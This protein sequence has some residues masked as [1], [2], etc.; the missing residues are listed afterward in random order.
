[1]VAGEPCL[2]L[3]E[4]SLSRGLI[5]LPSHWIYTELDSLEHYGMMGWNDTM[6]TA[7]LN[8]KGTI[9]FCLHSL[10]LWAVFINLISQLKTPHGEDL[11]LHGE[12]KEPRWGQLSRHPPPIRRHVSKVSG[13]SRTVQL[14][15]TERWQ[16]YIGKNHPVKH[17]QILIYK[18]TRYNGM[19]FV[20]SYYILR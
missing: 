15:S 19:L 18:A 20:S 13:L 3:F 5:H 9:S 14:N 8:C 11:R 10:N 6:L 2:E 4:I 1:M 7:G 16:S 12:D 17:A